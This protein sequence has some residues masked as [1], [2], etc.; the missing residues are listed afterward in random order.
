M[1]NYYLTTIIGTVIKNKYKDY[2]I[3]QMGA[4]A[5][6]LFYDYDYQGL[7]PHRL[8]EGKLCCPIV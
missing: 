1:A 7:R 3:P 4:G 2:A 6:I 8:E 5:P